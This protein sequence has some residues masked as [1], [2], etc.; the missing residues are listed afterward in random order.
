MKILEASSWVEVSVKKANKGEIMANT[1]PKIK[2]MMIA[3]ILMVMVIS[4]SIL[5]FENPIIV[6]PIIKRLRTIIFKSSLL[7][8]SIS[9]D[10]SLNT[11]GM[12]IVNSTNAS[13]TFLKY[14]GNNL[15]GEL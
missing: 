2:L 8:N 15:M 3:F 6:S 4:S 5:S 7:D 11:I 10:V 9:A 14:T 12:T 13:P 1:N